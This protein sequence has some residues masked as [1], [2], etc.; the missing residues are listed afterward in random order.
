MNNFDLRH[1]LY[2][3]PLLQE[4]IEDG[5]AEEKAFDAEF[6][7]SGEQI[8]AAIKKLAID[9]KKKEKQAVKE[10][11]NK[12]QI[13]EAVI[14]SVIAT[15]LTGNA[16]MGFI[17]KL[18]KKLFKKLNYTKGED[19][20]NKIYTFA[21]DNEAAFQAPIKRIVGLIVKDQE[22]AGLL[23]KAI[24]AIVILVMAGQAGSGA[25]DAVKKSDWFSAAFKTLKTLAKSDEVKANAAPIL[26]KLIS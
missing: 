22:K 19:I 2:N 9:A 16:I 24:Y 10:G 11:K 1:Y 8:A 7:A 21:H 4:E 12:E 6:D 25:I 23:T 20:A 3:N 26:L 5:G 17:A 13:N 18:A 14:T 15:I